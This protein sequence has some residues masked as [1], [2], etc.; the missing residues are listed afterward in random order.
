MPRLFTE[1]LLWFLFL[2]QLFPGVAI[3]SRYILFDFYQIHSKSNPITDIVF[4]FN[5]NPEKKEKKFFVFL[6]THLNCYS[7]IIVFEKSRFT[8]F[9][10][11][12][13]S[14]LFYTV[15]ESI[16]LQYYM[17]LVRTFAILLYVDVANLNVYSNCNEI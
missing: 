12:A 13:P 1:W 2:R 6:F 4:I 5:F 3:I 14:P 11:C 7:I 17:C 10:L 9:N 16:V 15:F 8:C